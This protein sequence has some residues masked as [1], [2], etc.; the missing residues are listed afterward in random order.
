MR[1]KG[2]IKGRNRVE[3]GELGREELLAFCFVVGMPNSMNHRD[4]RQDGEH[5][6]CGRH[7]V[8]ALKK[9]PQDDKH[10]AFGAFHEAYFA[11][12]DQGFCAGSGVADHQGGGHHESDE[13]DV[14]I[15]VAASVEDEKAE[16]ESDVGVAV[17]HGV[18]ERT[19]DG[20]LIGL[21]GNAAVHHVKQPGADDDEAGIQEH[22]H[23]VFCT[24]V[25]EKEGRDDIDD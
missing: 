16:E 8:P 13:A 20:D 18:E 5:P 24:R 11:G 17:E 6:E 2:G 12:A 19:E 15:A 1:R 22:P 14:K 3:E 10:D 4:G 23:V 9:G 7:G 21:A 25:T